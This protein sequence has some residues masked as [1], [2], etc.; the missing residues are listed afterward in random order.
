MTNRNFKSRTPIALAAALSLGLAACADDN[1]IDTIDTD[2]EIGA[3]DAEPMDTA[4]M[5]G[6]MV[7][8]ETADF[9]TLDPD[10]DLYGA[11]ERTTVQ[12][13]PSAEVTKVRAMQMDDDMKARR[14]QVDMRQT[15]RDVKTE[16][17]AVCANKTNLVDPANDADKSFAAVDRDGNGKLS[18]A[19]FAI[20]DL[21]NINPMVKCDK[22][23]GTRPFVSTKALNM[24][25]DDFVRFDRDGDAAIS[26]EEFRMA[27]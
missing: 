6:E 16:I 10:R 1:D 4:T 2:A 9:D 15:A 20:Y 25:A 14:R 3:V 24:S 11:R 7:D 27:S 12:A 18:P 17:D 23:D 22:D 21:A 13:Q 8:I 19:E 5:D 26:R